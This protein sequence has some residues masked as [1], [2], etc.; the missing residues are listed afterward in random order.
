MLDAQKYLD[1]EGVKYLWAK[2]NMQDYPNNK[3]LVSVINAI[4]ETKADKDELIQSDWNETDES[5]LAFIKNKPDMN[6]F[7]T[8][9]YVNEQ[10]Q[11]YVSYNNSQSLTYEQRETARKN[12]GKYVFKETKYSFITMYI[13]DSSEVY[14]R[15]SAK[16]DLDL[17]DAIP[18]VIDPNYSSLAIFALNLD[19]IFINAG[20]D[21]DRVRKVVVEFE[22][23]KAN[24][25]FSGDYLCVA[26]GGQ[27][28]DIK[29]QVFFG[30]GYN[31]STHLIEAE[32]IIDE[33]YGTIH[34]DNNTRTV[35]SNSIHRKKI[36]TTLSR[37]DYYADAK[38]V[39]EAITNLNSLV[40]E[41]K[42]SEQISNAI[43]QKSQVQII[44]WE[45]DD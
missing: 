15:P 9:D 45:A 8:Q 26:L 25:A 28:G 1:F 17:A 21:V 33:L 38:A 35:L 30:P 24:G 40:G 27:S 14:Q 29:H 12:I 31:G 3:T 11:G 41:T 7:A 32:S 39:G 20:T 43:A 22:N 10:T 13:A 4:D 16:I 34:W 19:F 2:I 37:S 18:S 44:T 23:M 5:S 6:S 42:V 36:D